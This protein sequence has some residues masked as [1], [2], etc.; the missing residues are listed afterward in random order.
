M[1]PTWTAEQRRRRDE[2]LAQ[3][4]YFINK[5]G[6]TRAQVEV[7]H[8]IYGMDRLPAPLRPAGPWRRKIGK[9]NGTKLIDALRQYDYQEQLFDIP[10]RDLNA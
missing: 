8:I 5:V 4:D 2:M 9:R 10:P 6:W 1:M 3:I 7:A